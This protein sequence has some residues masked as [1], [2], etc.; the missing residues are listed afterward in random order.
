MGNYFR[1]PN[2]TKWSNVIPDNDK[3]WGAYGLYNIKEL[4]TGMTKGDIVQSNGATLEKLSPTNHGD[5]LTSQGVGRRVI[6][7]APPATE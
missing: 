1:R 3:D 7:A 4:A 2:I 6:W 5:E